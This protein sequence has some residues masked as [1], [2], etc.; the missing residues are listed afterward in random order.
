MKISIRT[1]SFNSIKQF[2]LLLGMVILPSLSKNILLNYLIKNKKTKSSI[3]YRLINDLY[4]YLL[5]ITPVINIYYESIIFIALPY[6]Y[7]VFY[8]TFFIKQSIR[9]TIKRKSISNKL[10][11]IFHIIILLLVTTT[12]QVTLSP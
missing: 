3:A 1:Q 6:L 2:Y 10:V 12:V 11:N 8:S 4:I 7:Y 9:E 5:P